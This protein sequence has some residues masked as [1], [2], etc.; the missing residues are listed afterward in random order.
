MVQLIDE[1]IE[2]IFHVYNLTFT[3]F[4]LLLFSF[5]VKRFLVDRPVQLFNFI[6]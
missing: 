3:V 2:L 5:Q 4:E 1:G 6:Q